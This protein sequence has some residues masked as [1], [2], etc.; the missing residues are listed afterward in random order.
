MAR[1]EK[2]MQIR[3][4]TVTRGGVTVPCGTCTNCYKRRI[5][6][7]SFRLMQE[8][9]VSTSAYFVTL[10]YGTNCPISKN[11][12]MDLRKRD[13]QLWLKRLRKEHGENDGLTIKYYAVGEY[14]GKYSRPHYHII[15][16][17]A[18]LEYLIGHSMANHVKRGLIKL[19]GQ[20]PFE[21]RS[22][23]QGHVTIGQVS[24][25]SV[26]YTMKYVA[27]PSQ[28]PKHRNDDRTREFSLMSKGI[29]ISYLTDAMRAWHKADLQNRQY[30]NL[31]D[32]QKVTMPRYYK[33]KLMETLQE[34]E[35]L[36]AINVL[37]GMKEK[38]WER[39]SRERSESYFASKEKFTNN[40]NKNQKL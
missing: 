20:R 16:F 36:R 28:V 31:K 32:G 1:C 15:L 6:N 40:L 11:G 7:W 2:P 5:S 9:K 34:K 26:G 21:M 22:W 35:N 17:N 30:C 38:K 10:T 13:L 24:E 8:E 37:E 14:G 39:T 4:T 23:P 12:F 27:K 29:G 33:E 18:K 3:N 25:A 19:D